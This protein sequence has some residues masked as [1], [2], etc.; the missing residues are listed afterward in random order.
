MEKLRRDHTSKVLGIRP[1][2]FGISSHECN[3]LDFQIEP[4]APYIE[5][6]PG[7]R[8]CTYMNQP[9]ID[10]TSIHRIL[11]IGLAAVGDVLVA[12]PVLRRSHRFPEEL[13]HLCHTVGFGAGHSEGQPRRGRVCYG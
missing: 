3:G 4:M 8:Y 2:R 13:H 7:L 12:T 6:A 5:T 1:R 9:V 11:I 10:R